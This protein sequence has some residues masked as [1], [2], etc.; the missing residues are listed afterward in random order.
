M[1]L[2][3]QILATAEQE[4]Q[5]ALMQQ[6]LDIAAE[7]FYVIGISTPPM[8]YGIRQPYFHN[9]P[10]FIPQSWTYPT[11]AP[12]NPCQYFIEYEKDSHS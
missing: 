2:Y 9:V 10:D 6:V 4:K 8:Y 12:T 5:Y 3:K 1:S 11:P 7:Q